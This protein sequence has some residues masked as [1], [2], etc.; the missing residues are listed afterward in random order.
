MAGLAAG[1]SLRRAGHKVRIYERSALNNEVGA[2]I[3]VPPNAARVLVALG[4]DPVAARFVTVSS[5]EI[6]VGANRQVVNTTPMGAWLPAVYGAPLYFAHRVDLHEALKELAKGE[7]VGMPCEIILEAEVVGYVSRTEPR[8][9]GF[10]SAKT[11]SL[12]FFMSSTR[13]MPPSCCPPG[14]LPRVMSS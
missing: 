13:T 10:T 8:S 9:L 7:G 12:L 14:R 11:Y 4:L 5:I 1:I 3:N 2:A 6:G